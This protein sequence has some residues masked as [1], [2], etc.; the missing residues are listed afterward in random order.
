MDEMQK[1]ILDYVKEEYLE[2]NFMKRQEGL[3]GVYRFKRGFGGEIKR[4][5][6]VF[7]KPINR[8]LFF[9]YKQLLKVRKGILA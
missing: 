4:S 7:E 5:A 9:A 1:I 6:G 2:E 3:W 8:P